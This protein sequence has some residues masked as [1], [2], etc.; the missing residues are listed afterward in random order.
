MKWI[1]QISELME[2]CLKYC[3]RYIIVTKHTKFKTYIP[4]LHWNTLQLLCLFVQ[5][6]TMGS[7]LAG[8]IR[9]LFKSQT[10]YIFYNNHCSDDYTSASKSEGLGCKIHSRDLNMKIFSSI[11]VPYWGNATRSMMILLILNTHTDVAFSGELIRVPCAVLKSG[12]IIVSILLSIY[13]LD[14]TWG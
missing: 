2:G 11:P 13:H 7:D 14:R 4:N 8:M 5:Y 10:W 12:G 1:S 3:L 6:S 9:R